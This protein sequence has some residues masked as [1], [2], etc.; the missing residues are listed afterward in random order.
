MERAILVVV[1]W[2]NEKSW[3][4]E[5]TSQELALLAKSSGAKVAETITCPRDRPTPDY[6]IG[7]GKVEEIAGLCAK[8]RAEVIIFND[9]LSSTQ[10]RNLEE[11]IDTKTIDRT[12]LILDIFAGQAKS[13]EGKIQV[14]LAQLE[15]LLPRLVGKGI[16]LSR[17]GGGIGTRGPGEQK[18]EIDRRRIR[19]RIARLKD[20]LD[21]LRQRRQALREK[22]KSHDLPT[23]ALV[24]YTNAGKSTLLNSLTNA[25][26]AVQDK[27]FTTLD[28]LIRRLT[29]PNHQTVLLS[30]TVGFL[31]NLPHNLI[32][33]FKATLEEVKEADLLL[34]V[35]DIN[36]PL[37]Y[38][39]N[40]SVFEVLDEIG[41]KDKPVLTALNKIDKLLDKEITNV[42]TEKYQESVAISALKKENLD[43]LKEKISSLLL[44]QVSSVELVIPHSQM[45]LLN[46]IYQ[47]G[48]VIHTEYSHNDVHLTAQ[49]PLT[50]KRKL[51]NFLVS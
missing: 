21:S 44:N 28:P 30:D 25:H 32:E 18:L 17:L 19:K 51:S 46:L 3:S 2:Y 11:I 39:Q 1:D 7:K 27:L 37:A 16:I 41:V 45:R 42:L 36:H 5:D 29:L 22:R 4:V 15:Y 6:L 38:E 10:Q 26:Q 14:E 50:L 43:K 35:L 8:H 48:R 23:V 9:N 20:E 13:Q 49:I 12:Q 47:E 34:H 31:H 24:G 33:A 40:L